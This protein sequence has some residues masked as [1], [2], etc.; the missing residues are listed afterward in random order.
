MDKTK[1]AAIGEHS[2]IIIFH[3][4]GIKTESVTS[5]EEAETSLNNLI[6]EGYS[7]IF[8]TETIAENISE[9][10]RN[11]RKQAYPLIL[12]IPDRT[13][14]NGYSLKKITANM[15]KAIGKNIFDM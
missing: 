2:S 15:E 5:P 14:S 3:A 11:Y 10:L 12:P 1:I 6:R 13:G 7:I 9:T 8:I 4:A